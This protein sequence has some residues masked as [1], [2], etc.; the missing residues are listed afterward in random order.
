MC[1]FSFAFTRLFSDIIVYL[2]FARISSHCSIFMKMLERSGEVQVVRW[3]WSFPSSLQF[4]FIRSEIRLKRGWME[5]S[6]AVPVPENV[7]MPSMPLKKIFYVRLILL[8]L[9]NTSSLMFLCVLSS[10]QPCKLSVPTFKVL[11]LQLTLTYA[12]LFRTAYWRLQA[13]RYVYI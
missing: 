2:I 12:L 1:N 3:K 9:V 10:Q 7:I 8:S 4:A 6:I 13:V 5:F 11:T